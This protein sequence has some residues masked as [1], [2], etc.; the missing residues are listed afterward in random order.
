MRDLKSLTRSQK[1]VIV[2]SG[3]E[4]LRAEVKEIVHD[5]DEKLPEG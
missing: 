1:L 4:V 3:K 5:A 2:I